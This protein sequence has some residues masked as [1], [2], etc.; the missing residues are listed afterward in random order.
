M[1]KYWKVPGLKEREHELIKSVSRLRKL[2]AVKIAFAKAALTQ[3][4]SFEEIARYIGVSAA[5]V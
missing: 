1:M 5:A 3:G 4:Y 2:T